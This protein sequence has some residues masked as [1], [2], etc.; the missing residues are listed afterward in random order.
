[1]D[2]VLP[3]E[4]TLQSSAS[5]AKPENYARLYNIVERSKAIRGT[6]Q[7]AL[8]TCKAITKLT[9]QTLITKIQENAGFSKYKAK[10]GLKAAL[11]SIKRALGDGKVVE[12]PGIGRLTVVERKQRRVIRKNL[13][14]RC[15]CS[16]V[17]L[18][19]KHPRSVRLLR[20]K[21]LSDDPRPSVIHKNPVPEPIPARRSFAI[22]IPRFRG[23][24]AR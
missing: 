3:C 5:T 13:K 24:P 19:K 2:P 21:D 9:K 23:R 1:M 4:G 17:S 12:L 10:K 20:G 15:P 18:H 7:S 16:I 8:T 6:R 14:G 11:F 22:A